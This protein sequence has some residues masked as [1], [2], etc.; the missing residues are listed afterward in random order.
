MKTI[1]YSKNI[2][3]VTIAIVGVAAFATGAQ[4]DDASLGANSRVVHYS[5][6][7]LNTSA[8]A[9]V[10]Y[11]RI[12]GAAERVCGDADA[13]RMQ[14]VVAVKACVD[15]AIVSSVRAINNTQLNR[16]A[17]LHGYEMTTHFNLASAR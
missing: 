13:R 5:D 4:A 6:L 14:R 16:T 15:Q 8:G 7:N 2:A 9:K 10:L 3:L 17:D 1:N 12:L 11:Q